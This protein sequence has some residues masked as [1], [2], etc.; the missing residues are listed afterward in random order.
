MRIP[1]DKLFENSVKRIFS[2][3]KIARNLADTKAFSTMVP[4]KNGTYSA[5]VVFLCRSTIL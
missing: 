1:K 3:D 2:Q 4:G 5:R